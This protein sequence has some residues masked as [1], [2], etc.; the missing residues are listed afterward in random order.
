MWK[1][2]L[3]HHEAATHKMIKLENLSKNFYSRTQIIV[4]RC[5]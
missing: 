3:P 2:V 1:R 4:V 5:G